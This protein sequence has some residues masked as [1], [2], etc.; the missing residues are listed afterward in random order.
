MKKWTEEDIAS[1]VELRLDGLTWAEIGDELDIT[2]NKARKAFYRYMRDDAEPRGSVKGPKILVF[3]IETAPMEGYFWGL[4]KQNISLEMIK[5][6]TTILSW[7][8]KW[9]GAPES[10]VMYADVRH[11]ENKR[12]DKE[13]VMKIHS[14]LDE[15]D[16][17]LTQ[18]GERFDEPK[19]N[20][21]FLV[22][23]LKKPSSFRHE[24]TLRIAKAKFGF[25]SNKLVHMTHLFCKKY[26][27]LDHGEFHGMKLWTEC[28]AGNMKAFESMEKYNKYDV[29]SLEELYVDH[30]APW[31]NGATFAAYSTEVKFRCNC[32]SDSFKD[33]GFHITKRAK[34]QK[35][36]CNDCGREY[37]D[38][39]NLFS[40]AKKMEL[41]V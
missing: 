30:L 10:E 1:L 13:L 22:H 39:T 25:D 28:L 33:S 40:K 35:H 32:G 18:N 14:L 17:V 21:R 27:K 26:K 36:Q 15:A 11:Q 19:L 24:D 8:A 9:L 29:L 3:D 6:H 31:S 38:T 7:S 4:F 5:Q 12:D 20:Y 16:I 23:G 41:K 2:P 34:F 37:R